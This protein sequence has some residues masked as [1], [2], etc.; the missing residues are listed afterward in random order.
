MGSWRCRRKCRR[1]RYR[2]QCRHGR[3]ID[4]RIVRPGRK[5]GHGR[6]VRCRRIVNWR[7]SWRV[8]QRRNGWRRHYVVRAWQAGQLLLRKLS[9]LPGL[10]GGREVL[11]R[12]PVHASGN[13]RN[14]R[15][16]RKLGPGRNVRCRRI[17]DRW[18]G[19]KSGHE[20]CAR[21]AGQ[22]RLWQRSSRN[23]GLRG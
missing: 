13:W 22:L 14:V 15:S 2:W 19:W 7:N 9:R 8:G 5:L 12:M 3:H 20:L 6:I 17:V 10:R 4:G 21:Q 23:P 1:G 11:R 16:G 18:I